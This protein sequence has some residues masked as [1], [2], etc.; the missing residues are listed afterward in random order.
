MLF[1][2]QRRAMLRMYGF[3]AVVRLCV[4]FGTGNHGPDPAS[5]GL[6]MLTL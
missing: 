5:Q 6:T 4:A 1:C 3:A 2:S